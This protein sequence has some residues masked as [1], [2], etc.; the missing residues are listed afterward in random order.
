MP[1]S[2]KTPVWIGNSSS[3]V[4]LPNS[5][6]KVLGEKVRLIKRYASTYAICDANALYKG[7]V[8]SGATAGYI[9][10]QSTITPDR[11]N[12][13]LLT[14]EWEANGSGSGADLPVDEYGLLP[15]EVNPRLESHPLFAS[16]NVE[17]REK[18][19]AWVDASDPLTRQKNKDLVTDPDAI[20]L[21]EKLLQG[22]E[23]Y[24]L[25]GWTYQWAF[26]SWSIPSI[27]DGGFIETPGGPLSGYLGSGVDW[28][29]QADSYEFTGTHHKLTRTWLGGPT[30]HWDPDL[31]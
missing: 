31:Y 25:A 15:F 21:G 1:G 10:A 22:T 29:R 5:G 16:L 18:V 6:E 14:I 20:L 3:L 23:T 2:P 8:G 26:Y 12:Q 30:G 7:T 17:K 24:Y 13:A 9:V 27:S 19:R 11:G 4:E 28:L